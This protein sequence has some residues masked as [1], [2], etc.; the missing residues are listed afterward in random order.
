MAQRLPMI[1]ILT[2][3]ERIA[4][5]VDLERGSV[6]RYESTAVYCIS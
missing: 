2:A 1:A 3:R 4:A 6:C 5:P